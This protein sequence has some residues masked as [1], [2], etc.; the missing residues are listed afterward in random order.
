M[1]NG[2]TGFGRAAG[3]C[4]NAMVRVEMKSVNQRFLDV[5][6]RL[7]E[8]YRHLEPEMRRRIAAN[9]ARGKVDVWLEA[10]I[11]AQNV[12]AVLNEEALLQWLEKLTQSP[13]AGSLGMPHW[14]DVLALPDVLHPA[15]ETVV[16]DADI[17]LLFDQAMAELLNMRSAE[18][19]AIEQ[20]ILSRCESLEKATHDI[21]AKQPDLRRQTEEKLRQSVENLQI[22][23]DTGRFEQELVYLLARADVDEETDRLLLHIGELRRTLRQN[24]AIGRRID[25]LLQEINR[26]TNTL[27][28]KSA[29][30]GI[31]QQVVDM[32]VWIEQIREQVQNLE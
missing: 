1:R 8:G 11:S 17:M 22:D 30:A 15:E 27:G 2:M 29:D 5:H 9:M 7:P 16:Q 21:C 19:D 12:R 24:G 25:F 14:Q 23:V 10:K 13:A 26:E 4:G 3:E 18:G 6:V 31:S 20:L 28:T 32:K